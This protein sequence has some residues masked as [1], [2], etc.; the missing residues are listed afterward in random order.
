MLPLVLHGD[1]ITGAQRNGR[2]RFVH[3]PPTTPPINL[4][5]LRIVFQQLV[6]IE[7][8]NCVSYLTRSASAIIFLGSREPTAPLNAH[9]ALEMSFTRFGVHLLFCARSASNFP[10]P[11]SSRHEEVT[12]LA[13]SR[14]A[15]CA[16]NE[17]KVIMSDKAI[18]VKLVLMRVSS[19]LMFRLPWDS[20]RTDN[21][22][23][24]KRSLNDEL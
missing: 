3:S 2:Y 14:Q 15:L 18:I 17:N 22:S 5:L 8:R 12:A 20:L 6:Y 24:E 16:G 11:V 23:H 4:Q 19:F 21:D 7:L 9:H 10:S 13:I 1:L